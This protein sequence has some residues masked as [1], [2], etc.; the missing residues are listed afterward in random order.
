MAIS[1]AKKRANNKYNLAHYTVVGCKIKKEDAEAFKE[2]C[3]KRNTT[4]NEVFKNAINEFMKAAGPEDPEK[5]TENNK[6][7]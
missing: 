4:P 1:E 5:I 6:Y 7:Y 3:K 2:E